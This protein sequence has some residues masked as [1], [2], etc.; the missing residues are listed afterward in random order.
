V[1]GWVVG[2]IGSKSG[3]D[4]R[5]PAHTHRHTYTDIHTHIYTQSHVL[6][7]RTNSTQIQGL[8]EK[9]IHEHRSHRSKCDC[10]APGEGEGGGRR[11]KERIC[12]VSFCI[13]KIHQTDTPNV[14]SPKGTW[15]TA[16]ESS[17]PLSGC[18]SIITHHHTITTHHHQT[19]QA[20]PQ[21]ETK[22][23]MKKVKSKQIR[24]RGMLLLPTPT[25]YPYTLPNYT[26]TQ[27][28]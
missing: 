22:A 19:K 27:A 8:G 12:L 17:A 2:D 1:N 5:I 18:T 26:Q 14:L 9:E 20:L 15:K 23:G 10:F 13:V 24:G 28:R 21:N 6:H 7:N 25:T 11:A 3:L 16:G 4:Q